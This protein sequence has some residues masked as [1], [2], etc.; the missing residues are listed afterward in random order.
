MGTFDQIVSLSVQLSIHRAAILNRNMGFSLRLTL[1][2]LYQ[3]SSLGALGD[4]TQPRQKRPNIVV[5]MTDDVDTE[6]GTEMA[7]NKT[8]GWI[9]SQ[10]VQARRRIVVTT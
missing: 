2:L 6:L 8:R 3:L 5:F 4:V 10:G 1:I 7:L 9:H